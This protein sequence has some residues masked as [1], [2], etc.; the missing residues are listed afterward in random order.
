M[1]SGFRISLGFLKDY[2]KKY[3]LA[4]VI[5]GAMIIIASFFHIGVAFFDAE[6][7]EEDPE[8]KDENQASTKV[9]V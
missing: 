4:F 8:V 5:G 9:V 7:N 2:T 6:K 3:D 1:P